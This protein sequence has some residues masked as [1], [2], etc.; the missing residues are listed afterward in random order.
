ML[1][2]GTWHCVDLGLTNVLEER[3][4]SIFMVE[5]SVSVEPAWA[6]GCRLLLQSQSYFMTGGL[7][8]ISLSWHHAPSDSW[9]SNFT[10]QLNTC[11][12]SPYATSFLTRGW[13]C[14]SQ[15]LLGLASTVILRSE[16]RETHY[17]ILL[18][19]IRDS[20]NLDDQVHIFISPLNRWAGY[21]PRHWVPFLLP[22]TTHRATVEVY[23]PRFHMGMIEFFSATD[24]T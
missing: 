4:A 17:H 23:D 2:S 9:H 1:S 7:S 22:P 21:I 12:Y 11:G 13:V 10:F 14:R 8:P 20:P 3:M 15:L 19:Q 16:S 5:K 18:S 6:G 24:S